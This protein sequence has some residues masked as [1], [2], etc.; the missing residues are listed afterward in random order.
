MVTYAGFR[1]QIYFGLVCRVTPIL[2]EEN[3]L[4]LQFLKFLGFF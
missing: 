1:K 2:T 3:T 4:I